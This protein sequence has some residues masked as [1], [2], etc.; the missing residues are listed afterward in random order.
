MIF[1][2]IWNVRSLII[3]AAVLNRAFAAAHE[4][5]GFIQLQSQFRYV[6]F[7]STRTHA[8]KLRRDHMSAHY[9]TC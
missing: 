5:R 1:A 7:Q 2:E 6:S 8:W 3:H 4:R 9:T